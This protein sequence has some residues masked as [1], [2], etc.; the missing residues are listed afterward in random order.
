MNSV[1]SQYNVATTVNRLVSAANAKGL[2]V[3]GQREFAA[4]AGET[5]RPTILLL[6]GNPN[7]ISQLV[8]ASQV[9]AID[10]P[11]KMLV[12]QDTDGKVHIG[13]NDPNWVM[14]RHGV[15]ELAELTTRMRGSLEAIANEAATAAATA[16]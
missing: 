6:V 12:W 2:T 15:T 3:F 13:F 11:M 16:H 5:K 14:Q 9:L 1:V 8:N 7:V 10:L 4:G